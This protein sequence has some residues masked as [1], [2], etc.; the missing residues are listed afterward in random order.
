MNYLLEAVVGELSNL[1]KGRVLDLGCGDGDYAKRLKD[2]GFSVI[3]ADIDK[4]R[5]KYHREIEFQHCDI[6]EKIP[7]PDGHFDYVILMEVIEHLRNP[8]MVMPQIYRIIKKGGTLIISTP[9]ILSLKSRFRYLFEGA[10]EYFREMPLEQVRNPKENIFNLHLVP[11][12]YQELE[13]LLAATGFT[14]IKIFTS[15]YEGFEL[16]FLWPII[17]LQSWLKQRRSIRKG[18][19]DYRRLNQILL[20]KELLYGRHLMIRAVK[21]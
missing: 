1:A 17:K 11:Y 19:V 8:Y 2:I 10:Y 18:G 16:S 12:R 6:R 7:F 3:A 15:V 5:F 9:N 20:S 4:E 21:E 14:V 13:Y